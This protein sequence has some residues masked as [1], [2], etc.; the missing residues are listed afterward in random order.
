[1]AY[2]ERALGAIRSAGVRLYIFTPRRARDIPNV[3]ITDLAMPPALA[4]SEPF[5]LGVT[6]TN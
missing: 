2:A 1:M 4:K 5:A 6:A 3:A